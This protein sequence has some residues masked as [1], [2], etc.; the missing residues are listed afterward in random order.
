MCFVAVRLIQS[1]RDGQLLRNTSQIFCVLVGTSES[2]VCPP[3]KVLQVDGLSRQVSQFLFVALS[4]RA[5]QL[6]A[7][8]K[9]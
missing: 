8:F 2:R 4:A 3:L 7:I 9:L 5:I 1:T 6:L